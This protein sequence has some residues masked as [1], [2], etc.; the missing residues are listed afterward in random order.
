MHSWGCLSGGSPVWW[1]SPV[2]GCG[3]DPAE[4]HSPWACSPRRPQWEA[5]C[6][7]C[8]C[9][10]R[11][12]RH[13]RPPPILALLSWQTCRGEYMHPDTVANIWYTHTAIWRKILQLTCDYQDQNCF[14][15]FRGG[16]HFQPYLSIDAR[17]LGGL[18][19]YCL[20][21]SSNAWPM[22]LMTLWAKP[23]EHSRMWQAVEDK[24]QSMLGITARPTHYCTP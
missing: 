4:L 9:S 21:C 3:R 16:V 1:C 14:N 12:Q 6:P 2:A 22:V 18:C 7:G 19:R 17:V 20:N 24:N 8:C 23:S 13:P 11:D 15:K 5:P 10:N